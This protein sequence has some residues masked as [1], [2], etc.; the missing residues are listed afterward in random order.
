MYCCQKQQVAILCLKG[1]VQ[2]VRS[3]VFFIVSDW[4]KLMEVGWVQNVDRSKGREV[5]KCTFVDAGCRKTYTS[6]LTKG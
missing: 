1:M 6:H 3:G 4:I 2:I 5:N